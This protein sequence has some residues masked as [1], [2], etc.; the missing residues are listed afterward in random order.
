MP[1]DTTGTA[2]TPTDT[3]TGM[4][5]N[6]DTTG[7]YNSGTTGSTTGSYN[8]TTSTDTTSTSGTATSTTTR[9]HRLPKTASDLPTVA[10][11]GLLALFAAFAVRSYSKRDA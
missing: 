10:L 2:T 5:N 4:M 9:S 7:S 1:T 8:N 11:A 6:T 3:T